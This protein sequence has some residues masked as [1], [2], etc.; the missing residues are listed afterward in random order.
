MIS[1]IKK[2]EKE[3]KDFLVAVKEDLVDALAFQKKSQQPPKENIEL[4]K[5][6]LKGVL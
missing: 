3:L 4:A 1:I 6:R 5:Q 2:C